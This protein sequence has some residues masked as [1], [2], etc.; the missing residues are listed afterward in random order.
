MTFDKLVRH[1]ILA[2]AF[3]LTLSAAPEGEQEKPKPERF[4]AI[5]IARTGAGGVTP[6]DIVVERW[7]TPAERERLLTALAEKGPKGFLETLRSLPRVAR[8]AALGAIGHDVRY[9]W[10]TKNPN[11]M[12]EILLATDRPIGFWEAANMPRS[13]EYPITVIEF[14]LKPSG[15]GEGQAIVA[16]QVRLNRFN[17]QIE[18]ENYDFLPVMLNS[19]RRL[20]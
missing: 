4:T 11:G 2:A 12:D 13:I 10:L 16:A 19:V 5:A 9:A 18:V 14:R 20:K 3:P 7:S 15:E 17:K 1:L 8:F 6:I